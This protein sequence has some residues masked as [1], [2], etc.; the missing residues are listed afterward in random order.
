[1][2]TVFKYIICFV[3][4]FSGVREE[5]F[6]QPNLVPNPSFEN[7][8]ACDSLGVALGSVPPWDSPTVGSPD[9]FNTCAIPPSQQFNVP[10][11]YYGYQYP[12]TGNGYVGEVIFG[13]GQNLRE[14]LQVQLDSVLIA[15]KMYCVSFYT[16]KS[17]GNDY[18]VNNMG[19]YFSATHTQI[20]NAYR[21]NLTP[22]IIDTNII[23]DTASWTLV[24]GTYIAQG[25]EQ[26]III[27]NFNTEATTDTLAMNGIE[28][29]SYYYIDDVTIVD[30]TGSGFGVGELT[31][32]E[33][34]EIFP[35][36][37][38][39]ILTLTLTNGEGKKPLYIYNVLGEIVFSSSITKAKT[40]I[41]ISNLPLGIYF[42]EVQ[43]EKKT[44]R[45]K[46]VKQ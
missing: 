14:Y 8:T 25:G 26:Y 6:S 34:I 40:E 41:D 46:F 11:N 7:V 9:I 24:S 29:W 28:N 10:T 33:G 32:N 39:T 23:S 18:A 44:A 22:Q 17:N 2:K 19:L 27:G 35:N 16:S 3:L 30:C 31:E 21:L 13:Q 37:A 5:I 15:N 45:T 43:S 20:P 4:L 36:P 12:H 38:T 1:M 42:V